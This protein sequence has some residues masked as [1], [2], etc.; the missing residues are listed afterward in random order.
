[1]SSIRDSA[2]ETKKLKMVIMDVTQPKVPCEEIYVFC[3]PFD[4]VTRHVGLCHK[5]T[6]GKKKLLSD[7]KKFEDMIKTKN[8]ETFYGLTD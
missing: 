4:Y 8:H 5:W 1:M 2:K 6:N 3:S 7:H